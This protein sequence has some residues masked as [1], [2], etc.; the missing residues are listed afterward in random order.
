MTVQ[1]ETTLQ[2][3]IN[4]GIVYVLSNPAM[5]GYI[6][7]GKTSGDSARNVIGRM[8]ELDTTGIP[9]AFHCEYAA[10]VDDNS[11]VEKNLHIMWTPMSRQ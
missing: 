4:S 8:R 7:I 11:A 5:D 9:R 2:A 1:S 10:V 6:K 3:N